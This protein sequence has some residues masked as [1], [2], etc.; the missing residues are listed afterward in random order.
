MFAWICPK[1]GKEIP[2]Q[3]DGCPEW[4]PEFEKQ[5]AQ[6]KPDSAPPAEATSP[7]LRN[8]PKL[9]G[10]VSTGSALAASTYMGAT[11]RPEASLPP[12][13]PVVVPPPPTSAAIHTQPTLSG[14]THEAPQS[15]SGSAATNLPSLSDIRSHAPT[16]VESPAE[17]TKEMNPFL[18]TGYAAFKY[19]EQSKAPLSVATETGGTTGT[20]GPHRLNRILS[21]TGM[22]FSPGK[23]KQIEV[24]FVLVNESAAQTPTFS[25]E[26]AIRPKDASPTEPAII[27]FALSKVS[28]GPYESKQMRIPVVTQLKQYEL[29][30]SSMIRVDFTVTEPAN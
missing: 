25:G 19:Y 21:F 5:R 12:P 22:T 2:P 26:V 24:Q 29:P 13:P 28:L 16:T 11:Y 18:V 7:I 14:I 9:E 4:C 23:N 15:G 20:N 10:T 1:C 27:T 30:D 8:L 6:L 17:K 3:Y